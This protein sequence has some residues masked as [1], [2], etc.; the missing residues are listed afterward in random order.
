MIA[1]PALLDRPAVVVMTPVLGPAC[2]TRRGRGP[3]L[4]LQGALNEFGSASAGCQRTQTGRMD[5][6]PA[7]PDGLCPVSGTREC[8]S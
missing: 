2:E 6:F 3:R 7:K 4:S 5:R 8:T 1:C